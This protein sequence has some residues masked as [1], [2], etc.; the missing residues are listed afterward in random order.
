ME[1]VFIEVLKLTPALGILGYFAWYF[2]SEIKTKDEEIKNLNNTIRDL[3]KENILTMTK[4]ISVVE[5]LKDLIKEI[6]D[7]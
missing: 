7:K 1:Q 3:Q 2:K 4:L 5:D 6:K